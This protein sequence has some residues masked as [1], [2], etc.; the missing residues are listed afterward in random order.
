VCLV[1]LEVQETEELLLEAKKSLYE[2]LSASNEPWDC[3][4]CD[5]NCYEGKHICYKCSAARP[6]TNGAGCRIYGHEEFD[7]LCASLHSHLDE[8]FNPLKSCRHQWVCLRDRVH[9][10]ADGRG[11]YMAYKCSLCGAFQRRYL[12]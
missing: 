10:K 9:N 1:S 4:E 8:Q 2:K 12:K 3:P 6:E 7:G 5:V 11:K